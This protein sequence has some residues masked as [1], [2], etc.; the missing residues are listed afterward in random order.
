MNPSK[1]AK[2]CFWFNISIMLMDLILLILTGNPWYLLTTTIAFLCA[3]WIS[4]DF[5]KRRKYLETKNSA[6]RHD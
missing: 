5:H 6:K 3:W 4:H 1:I 2:W